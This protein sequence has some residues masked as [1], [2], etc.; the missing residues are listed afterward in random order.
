M[1]WIYVALGGAIGACLRFAVG[2]VV[3]FP[4]GT[5][6][7]NVIG[8]FVMGVAFVVLLAHPRAAIHGPLVM[9]GALGAFTTFSA[10]SL[11]ALKLYESGRALAAGGYVLGTVLLSVGALICGVALARTMTGGLT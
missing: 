9:T 3:T 8:S 5:L 6:A 2:Q 7:V 1:A 10:F 4:F 11:D